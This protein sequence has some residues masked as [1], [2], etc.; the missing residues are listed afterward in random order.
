MVEDAVKELDEINKEAIQQIPELPPSGKV[1][2]ETNVLFQNGLP[3][4]DFT[5]THVTSEKSQEI[6]FT[7]GNQIYSEGTEGR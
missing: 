6:H 1:E 5:S 7:E 2:L 3:I 4:F